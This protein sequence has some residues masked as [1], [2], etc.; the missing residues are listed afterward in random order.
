MSGRFNFSSQ[1]AIFQA[2]FLFLVIS[3]LSHVA[4]CNPAIEL[5]GNGPIARNINYALYGLAVAGALGMAKMRSYRGI[6][7]VMGVG[8][9]TSQNT[10]FVQGEGEAMAGSGCA[11]CGLI[12]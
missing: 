10:A 6:A 11:S 5:Q 12:C 3:V 7:K 8:S 2:G 9:V 1:F 4:E